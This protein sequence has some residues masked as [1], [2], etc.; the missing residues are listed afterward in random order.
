MI[1]EWISIGTL[2]LCLNRP[3]LACSCAVAESP[4]DFVGESSVV[5]TGT[6]DTIKDVNTNDWNRRVVYFTVDEA[7]SG[8]GPKDKKVIVTT[9][10]GGGDCGFPFEK[11]GRYLVYAY[12]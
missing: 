7:L 10:F 12:E 8:L 6:V 3:V 5:F 4:C 9:G 11:A 2:V 1:R